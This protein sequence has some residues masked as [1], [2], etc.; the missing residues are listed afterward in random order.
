[1]AWT[2]AE[3]RTVKEKALEYVNRGEK[4]K[5]TAIAKYLP[6]KNGRAVKNAWENGLDPSL[7]Q[8]EF[9]LKEVKVLLEFEGKAKK[10]RQIAAQG[11]MLKRTSSKIRYFWTVI[12]PTLKEEGYLDENDEFDTED[13]TV[14]AAAVKAVMPVV[15]NLN[16][17][18][19]AKAARKG[20]NTE[21][22][23]S[24]ASMDVAKVVANNSL[25]LEEQSERKR[26]RDS[27]N[28]TNHAKLEKRLQGMRIS[29]ER[30]SK[31]A[32]PNCQEEWVK[33]HRAKEKWLLENGMTEEEL[34]YL[35][36]Y[37]KTKLNNGTMVPRRNHEKYI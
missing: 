1:M 9:M 28:T 35:V 25:E 4:I 12:Q 31:L 23:A 27:Y 10:K 11:R 15:E 33:E 24:I 18:G 34:K 14:L 8:G 30:E 26:K 32:D 22:P 21:A 2:D 7:N 16:N 29:H 19:Q 17:S 5:W 3:K 13:D 6:G 20:R 36:D 37:Y